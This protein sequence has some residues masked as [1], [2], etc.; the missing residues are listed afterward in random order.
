M[1]RGDALHAGEADEEGGGFAGVFA[2][3]ARLGGQR[4]GLVLVF[5]GKVVVD[6]LVE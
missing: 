2:V 4:A 1:E 3:A 5:V 6:D